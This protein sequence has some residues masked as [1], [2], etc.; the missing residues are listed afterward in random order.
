MSNADDLI[1]H[2]LISDG[3]L[4]KKLSLGLPNAKII[5]F[6]VHQN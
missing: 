2:K 5:E 3:I 4:V 6:N 1:N